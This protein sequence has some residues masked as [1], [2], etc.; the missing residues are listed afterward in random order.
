MGTLMKNTSALP[1]SSYK[2]NSRIKSFQVT[3]NNILE[4][5][6]SLDPDK[7]HVCDITSIKMIQQRQFFK[8]HYVKANFQTHG[9]KHRCVPS[10]NKKE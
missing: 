4:I 5:V 3:E 8:L 6:K 2:T 9:K 10:S 1:S 7:A